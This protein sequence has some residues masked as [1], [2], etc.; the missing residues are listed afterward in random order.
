MADLSK[1]RARLAALRAK[2]EANGCTEAEALAAAEKAAELMSTYEL[3]EADLDTPDLVVLTV[4]MGPRRTPI[5][6]IW[7]RVATFANCS[8]FFQRAGNRWEYAYVGS[9]SDVLIA[10]YVHEVIRRAADHAITDFRSTEEYRKRRKPK[11][12]A[13]ALKAF[14]EG[15]ALSIKSKIWQGL[16]RRFPGTTPEEASRLIQGNIRIAD[17]ALARLGITLDPL[18]PV[19]KATGRSRMAALGQGW[20]AGQP[21]AIEASVADRSQPAGILS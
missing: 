10:E 15:F 12:R 11:T 5:D 6:T 19:Q 21:F 2:T 9:S 14:Q 1:I 17:G 20:Q 16:W 4:Q 13:A 8:G 3:T 7:R 18:R